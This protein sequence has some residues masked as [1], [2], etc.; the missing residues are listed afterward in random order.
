MHPARRHFLVILGLG[1]VTPLASADNT[2]NIMITGYWPPTANM[3]QRFSTNP[4][5]NPEGW[6]GGNWEGRG[7]NV[8]S[9]FPTFIDDGDNNWGQGSGDFEVDYQDT[10]ADWQRITS[11]IK[12]AAIITFSRGNR[13]TNWEIESRHNLRAPENWAADYSEPFRPTLDMPIFQ[14]LDIGTNLYSSLPM[15]AIR[16][17]VIDSGVINNAY[18]DE[19]GTGGNYL[20]EFIGLHGVWYNSLNSAPDAEWRN[21]AAG[22]I[23]VGI[24]TPLDAAIAATEISIREVTDYL[25][26]VI[27]AP[28]TLAAVAPLVMVGGVG[29]RA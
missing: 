4:E 8:Y 3:V 7:Y 18:I 26:T 25:D 27:P 22:H 14:S 23:H 13:G 19:N 29:R 28:G 12:P 21:F 6:V 1:A 15:E 5:L 9:Y 24:N 17:A 20:S 11:E 10:S 16:D 2:R